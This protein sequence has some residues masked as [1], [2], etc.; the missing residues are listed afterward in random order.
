MAIY[1]HNVFR[2]CGLKSSVPRQDYD[3]LSDRE[4][5]YLNA[6][7]QFDS[8]RAAELSYR[9]RQKTAAALDDLELLRSTAEVW[10]KTEPVISTTFVCV[11]T[12][13]DAGPDAFDCSSTK[14]LDPAVFNPETLDEW[15]SKTPSGWI[16]SGGRTPGSERMLA[17][18]PDCRSRAVD[19]FEETGRIPC[20]KPG[21]RTHEPH[22]DPYE[23]CRLS[24]PLTD[25]EHLRPHDIP[26]NGDR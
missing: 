5:E 14:E 19:W 13:D 12:A 7:E 25:E 21:H 24:L 22:S 20:G 15:Y 11:F 6:P 2:L 10:D 8:Q 23:E 18:C 17:V 3:F 1:H 26:L 9:I 4:R 16:V